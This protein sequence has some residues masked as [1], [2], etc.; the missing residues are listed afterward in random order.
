MKELERK[1]TE[2]SKLKLTS[3]YI[4]I[5]DKLVWVASKPLKNC[6]LTCRFGVTVSFITF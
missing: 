3:H 5:V 1:T 4:N 6:F 2:Q